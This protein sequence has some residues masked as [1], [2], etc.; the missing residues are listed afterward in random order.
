MKWILLIPLLVGC[1][2]GNVTHGI[3]N[4]AV[5]KPG[6][7]R[8]GQPNA[9]GWSY[10]KSLGVANV[11]KLNPEYEG[12]DELAQALGMTIYVCP[13]TIEQQMGLHQLWAATVDADVCYMLHPNTFVHCSHGQDRTGLIV[14]CY[15]LMVDGWSKADAEK[16]ML[17]HGFHKELRGLWESWENFDTK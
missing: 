7:Y 9:N 10:L 4:F 2:A 16:E 12:S 3:P 1:T 17:A 11:V 15:R 14:A 13:I 5:V 6:I 8:G